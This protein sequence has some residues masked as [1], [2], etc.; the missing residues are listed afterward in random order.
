M[1]LPALSCNT[2]QSSVTLAKL[3]QSTGLVWL[4]VP[5]LPLFLI[6]PLPHGPHAPYFPSPFNIQ[7]RD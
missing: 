5:S 1:I 4:P 6:P 2:F 3:A 7:E